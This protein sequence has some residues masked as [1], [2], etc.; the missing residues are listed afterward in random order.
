MHCWSRKN[1]RAPPSLVGGRNFSGPSCQY[2]S[3]LFGTVWELFTDKYPKGRTTSKS[4][5]KKVRVS[6]QEPWEKG[7][8]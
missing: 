2:L 5:S 6:L 1:R 3:T 4:S 7:L 8:G